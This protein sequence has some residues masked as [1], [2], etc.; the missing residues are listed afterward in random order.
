MCTSLCLMWFQETKVPIIGCFL[1]LVVCQS[2]LCLCDHSLC[3]LHAWAPPNPHHTHTQSHISNFDY[4]RCH[5][6]CLIKYRG[7]WLMLAWASVAPLCGSLAFCITHHLYNISLS[8]IY[9]FVHTWSA[10]SVVFSWHYCKLGVKGKNNRGN[11]LKHNR[12]QSSKNR[13]K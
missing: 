2:P 12:M 11:E 7:K 4:A 13:E 8:N 10:S 3:N 5:F 6:M 1:R 9:H